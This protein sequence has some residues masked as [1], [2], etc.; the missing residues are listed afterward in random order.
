M[1][2]APEPGWHR[3]G[4]HSGTVVPVPTAL[5]LVVAV[6]DVEAWVAD[7]LLSVAEQAPEG[8]EVIVVDDGSTDL[9][10]VICD[11]IARGRVN[12]RVIHQSNKGLGAVRNAGLDQATGD[13]VGFIDGD[14][15][16][17]PAYGQLL[18]VA[19][20][21]DLDVATGAVQRTDGRRSWVSGLHLR[22]LGSLGDVATMTQSPLMIYD[23]TAWNKVYRRSFLEKHGLRFPEGVLYE[24][25]PFTIPALYYAG[26][27]ACVHDPVYAWRT[28][29][30]G[31]SITQRRNEIRN[32]ADRFTA[33]WQVDAF[34]EAQGQKK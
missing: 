27:V 34:L 4:R 30:Q 22:A 10:G 32:L 24:D 9:S 20:S 31:L 3:P 7:C 14:D 8:T 15:M 21:R 13:Y 5:S 17:L 26:E 2:G 33:I 16:L 25:L 12:W 1:G 11:E 19:R 6:Y 23:T 18:A 29:Q 28:R